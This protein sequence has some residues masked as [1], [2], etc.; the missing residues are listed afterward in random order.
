MTHTSL[1]NPVDS[2][3]QSDVTSKNLKALKSAVPYARSAKSLYGF[4]KST[5]C[6]GSEDQLTVCVCGFYGY[7]YII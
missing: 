3:H 2:N 1:G 7:I 4:L 6:F 5:V